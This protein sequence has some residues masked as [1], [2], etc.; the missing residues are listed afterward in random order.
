M[1][2]NLEKLTG[3]ISRIT[4]LIASD[5]QIPG[6]LFNIGDNTV[7]ICYCDGSN[8][9]FSEIV[10][11]ET[12]E[13][14]VKDKVV[15]DYK[16]L[17]NVISACKP[18]ANST[19][20]KVEFRFMDNHTVKVIAE[21]K[22]KILDDDGTLKREKV[23]SISEQDLAWFDIENTVKIKAL[24]VG[25]YHLLHR[26]EENERNEKYPDPASIRPLTPDEW[27]GVVEV[28]DKDELAS[29]LSRL[30]LDGAA[31]KGKLIHTSPKIK[32]WEMYV[33]AYPY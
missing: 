5:K 31:N 33:L 32:S 27:K 1:F 19:T 13:T 6:V 11:V 26:M 7:E 16:A 24:S 4:N 20:E 28:W 25:S 12:S 2:I 18:T 21:K 23:A 30:A 9:E 22:I 8:K 3:A 29:M 15:F 17:S 14:D 10:D